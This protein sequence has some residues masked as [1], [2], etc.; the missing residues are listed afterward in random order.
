[1]SRAATLGEMA[2]APPM[3]L[4]GAPSAA[5][6]AKQALGRGAKLILGPV[7]AADVRPV[8][9]AVAGRAPVLAFSNDETLIE[10]G[11]FL[12][13]LGAGQCVSAILAYARGRGI[14]SVALLAGEGAWGVQAARAAD[15]A[16]AALGLTVRPVAAA[17]IDAALRAMQ[18]DALLAVDGGQGFAAA[19]RAAAAAEVQLLGTVQALDHRPATLAAIAGAW[20]AAPD[21]TGLQHF[22]SDSL[23]SSSG[24]PG[25]LAALAHDAALIAARVGAG[26]RPALLDPAGFTGA[27]GP[28]RFRQDGSAVR[29]LA[30]L[31]A[32]ADGYGIVGQ[33]ETA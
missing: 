31:A 12:L 18:P 22:A 10:S 26:G 29:R 2:A 20:L 8:L 30:I 23:A 24:D 27:L 32:A 14:R 19:A 33:S 21:P 7:Y 9:A 16:Q 25:L 3:V 28:V 6:A 11:A 4:D 17:G 13:G 5:A 1:M 15:R